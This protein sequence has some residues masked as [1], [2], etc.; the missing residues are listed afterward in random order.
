MKHNL[1]IHIQGTPISGTIDIPGSLNF[2]KKT[3]T[4]NLER[5]CLSTPLGYV[6][7]N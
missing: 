7:I 4:G 3:W 1:C 5:T 2:L 6:A